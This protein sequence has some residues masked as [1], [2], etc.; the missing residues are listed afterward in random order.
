MKLG[1]LGTG[2]VGRAIASK[3]VAVG[4][5]VFL[6]SR[7]A[8]NANA[9]EWAAAAGSGASH[10]TFG[11][12]A[13]FGEMVFNC[14]PGQLSVEI[15]SALSEALRGKIIV[16]VAN[17]LDF[18]QGFPPRLTVCNDDS[19]AEQIQRALPESPVVKSLNTMN[20]DVMVNPALVPGG[21]DVFLSGD[22]DEAKARVGDI[23][24]AFG[25]EDPIDLG[26][27]TSAR[28][29]EMV[30]PLWLRLFGALGTPQFQLKVVRGPE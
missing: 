26:D 8:D 21:H 29:A 14:T 30:L 28:G 18:S 27:L 7:T 25:W 15:L 11:E 23:L 6:G 12:A 19:L 20:S 10:G 1:V 4:Y 13:A 17:P 5:E 9:V 2:A 24:R 3:L 16:D 22:D